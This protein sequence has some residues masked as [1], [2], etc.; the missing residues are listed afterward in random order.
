MSVKKRKRSGSG[1][2]YRISGSGY[3]ITHNMSTFKLGEKEDKQRL[4]TFLV[5]KLDR[6]YSRSF[7]QRLILEGHIRVNQ[8]ET[9]PHHRLRPEDIVFANIPA[10][11]PVEILPENI[12]LDIVFEDKDLLVVNKPAGMIVHPAAGNYSQT[13]LNA[14]LF[15]CRKLSKCAGDLRAGIVHRLDKDTSGLMVVAKTDIAFQAISKQ[16]RNRRVKRRY[17]AFVKGNL[18]L[19]EG[20]ID[21]P[22]GRHKKHREKIAVDYESK[23]CAVTYYKLIKRFDNFTML[24]LTPKTGRTHQIRVHLSFIGH[25]ILGDLKYGGRAK[26]ISRQALHA[27]DLGFYHPT[28]NKFVEFRSELPQ[29]MKALILQ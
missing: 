13:L 22:L 29:D 25:P 24:E 12:P 8:I 5:E 16:F 14:L 23:K 2:R 4:D 21:L 7:I 20:V 27:V 3:P 19:N 11:V 26:E 10:Q 28:L 6:H 18:Q 1:I 17:I 15:R 9:K